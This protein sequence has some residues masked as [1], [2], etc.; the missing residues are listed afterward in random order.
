VNCTNNY[1]NQRGRR[2]VRS[3]VRTAAAILLLCLSVPALGQSAGAPVRT[4]VCEILKQPSL[5]NGKIVRVSGTIMSG[6]EFLTLADEGCGP[7][8]I[9]VAG[10]PN[11]QPIPDF[12]VKRDAKLAQL[13]R[14]AWARSSERV[15]LIGRLDGVD[16]VT[17]TE[18]L[19]N[20]QNDGKGKASAVV[21]L[22]T[23]GF[24]HMGAYRARLVLRRVAHI[25]AL[26]AT[27]PHK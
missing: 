20:Y 7:I 2:S 25:S 23:D 18:N 9:D 15:T 10:D 3:V 5:I 8:W 24:G 26:P 12:R 6:F 22:H 4:T 11:I 17:T 1:W 19:R 27:S 14:M 16:S 13:E 21:E